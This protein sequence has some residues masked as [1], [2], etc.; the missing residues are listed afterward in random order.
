MFTADIKEGVR[1][2]QQLLGDVRGAFG[3]TSGNGDRN[4]Y[5]F[6]SNDLFELV[7]HLPEFKNKAGVLHSN[8]TTYEFQ[9]LKSYIVQV[10]IDHE[11][12]GF[13]D[14]FRFIDATSIDQPIKSCTGGMIMPKEACHA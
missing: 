3:F 8:P 5:W 2:G 11:L 12:I 14:D 9:W 13:D 4:D 1:K 7:K 6:S 10:A